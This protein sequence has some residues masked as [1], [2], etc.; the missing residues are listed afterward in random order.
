MSSNVTYIVISKNIQ[1]FLTIPMVEKWIGNL[2]TMMEIQG[3]LNLGPRKSKYSL[4]YSIV[5]GDLERLLKQL[6]KR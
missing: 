2:K 6:D 1:K 3:N 5:F 4:L